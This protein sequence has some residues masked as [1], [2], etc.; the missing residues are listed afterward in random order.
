[1]IHKKTPYHAN[2]E[3]VLHLSIQLALFSNMA[4]IPIPKPPAVNRSLVILIQP[5]NSVQGSAQHQFILSYEQSYSEQRAHN[6]Q[7]HLF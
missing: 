4:N 3:S 2:T 5:L 7:L 1:M 6:V